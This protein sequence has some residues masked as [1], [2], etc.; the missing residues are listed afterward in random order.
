MKIIKS[1][2]QN[3]NVGRVGVSSFVLD[4]S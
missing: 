4:W 2:W 3:K 1:V